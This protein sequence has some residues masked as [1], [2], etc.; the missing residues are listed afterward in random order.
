LGIIMIQSRVPQ[1]NVFNYGKAIQDGQAIAGN[2]LKVREMS[3]QAQGVE[4]SNA[5][6]QQGVSGQELYTQLAQNNFGDVANA[7]QTEDLAREKE[8]SAYAKTKLEGVYDDASMKAAFQQLHQA[9]AVMYQDSVAQWGTDYQAA[10]AG[11]DTYLGRTA[12]ES[13][14]TKTTPSGQKYQVKKGTG[15]ES[16]SF[17]N[18]PSSGTTVNVGLG[19]DD[20][21][22]WDQRLQDQAKMMGDVKK[23]AEASYNEMRAL[24]RF[25]ESSKGTTAGGAQPI[26]SGVKNFLSSFGAEFK[27]LKDIAQMEQAIGDIKVNF[28]KEFGARGLTDKDM[29]IIK[30]SLPRL[31]TSEEARENVVRILKKAH[32][33]SI[34]GYEK[35]LEEEKRIYPE[36]A[37]KVFTP[38]WYN[39]Y[40]KY[41][42]EGDLTPEEQ[43]E[44]SARESIMGNQGIDQQQPFNKM[45]RTD[46]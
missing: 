14:E 24:D 45:Q 6:R 32:A 4:A 9:G 29:E 22:Y 26:I 38:N 23:R 36:R 11:I 40:V 8:K 17:Q 18:E 41:S 33:K 12:A 28:F 42:Q 30:D 35:S 37:K 16:K 15:E 43:A 1:G 34:E 10:K 13:F 19:K 21:K 27:D 2:A 46:R 25:L 20:Q 5:L 31:N 3:R 39:E 7:A 44:L